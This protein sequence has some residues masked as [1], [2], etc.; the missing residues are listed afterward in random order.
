MPLSFTEHGLRFEFGDAWSGV[1]YDG[2]RLYR[3]GIISVPG[4]KALDFFGL[5]A[6][7]MLL[8]FEA[9]DYRA[10]ARLTHGSTAETLSEI[11]QKVRDTLAGIWAARLRGT[12]PPELAKVFSAKAVRQVV[13]AWWREH[14]LPHNSRRR[15]RTQ[16]GPLRARLASQ[17]NWLGC[18]AL[19][20]S[21]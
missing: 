10:T 16:L 19:V 3:S 14:D 21:S 6:G 8:F 2:H 5:H 18:H 20:L 1:K 11:A 13:L 15:L 7:G 17:S 4:T 12:L 9:N